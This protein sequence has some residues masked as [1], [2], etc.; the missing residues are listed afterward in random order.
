MSPVV[1]KLF[2]CGNQTGQDRQVREQKGFRVIQ[3]VKVLSHTELNLS[4]QNGCETFPSAVHMLF[5]WH[6]F[7]GCPAFWHLWAT[8]EEELSWATH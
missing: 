1:M 2:W 8:L 3:N 6:Y 4:P 5:L 7:Q